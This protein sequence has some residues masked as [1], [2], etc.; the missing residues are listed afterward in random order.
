MLKLK[1]NNSGAKRLI[2]SVVF[3]LSHADRHNEST[4][5]CQR[6]EKN[7][8]RNNSTESS[9]HRSLLH[10]SLNVIQGVPYHV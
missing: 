4:Y 3:E 5:W 1:K 9:H 8:F 2:R 6:A 7:I 10:L